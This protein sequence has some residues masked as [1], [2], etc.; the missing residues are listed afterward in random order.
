MGEFQ[1]LDQKKWPDFGHQM[2]E[3]VDDASLRHARAPLGL[4]LDLSVNN[5]LIKHICQYQQVML[6]TSMSKELR[7]TIICKLFPQSL[8][9]NAIKWFCQL[10]PA[11]VAS[12]KELTKTFLENYSVNIYTGTTHEEL[13]SIVQEPEGHNLNQHSSQL[14]NRQRD[15][16]RPKRSDFRRHNIRSSRD[17]RSRQHKLRMEKCLLSRPNYAL[18]TNPERLVMHLQDK[19]YICWPGKIMTSPNHRNMDLFYVFHKDHSH[20]TVNCRVLNYEIVELL[21]Q[22]HLKVFLSDK[23]SQTYGIPK[24][25]FEHDKRRSSEAPSFHQ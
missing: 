21:K 24:D 8:K 18:D 14:T 17:S 1:P 7:D 3:S 13:F 23:G 20:L 25:R 5:L 19:D 11:L 15:N 12:F 22:G 9:G 10:S 6:G 16:N 2:E 4:A